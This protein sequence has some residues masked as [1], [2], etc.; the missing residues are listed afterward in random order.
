MIKKLTGFYA[1]M[2]FADVVFEMAV[3]Y[4]L[5]CRYYGVLM[6]KLE[7]GGEL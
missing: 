7:I 6:Q 1:V 2:M 4:G 3:F 5:L